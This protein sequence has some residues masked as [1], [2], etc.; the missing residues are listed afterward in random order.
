MVLITEVEDRKIVKP[1]LGGWR[2]KIT[3]I[4]YLNAISQTGPPPKYTSWNNY[5]SIGIQTVETKDETT[6]SA[7]NKTTQM[8]RTDYNVSNANDKYMTPKCYE[9]Y[10]D[11]QWRLDLNHRARI[12]QRNYRVYR[13]LKY[14][15]ECARKYREILKEC[16]R[17][18]DERIIM[19]RK[20]HEQELLRKINPRSRADFDM[21]IELIERWRC[22]RIKEINAR[23]FKATQCAENCFVLK[24]TVEMFNVIDKF[25]QKIREQYRTRKRVKFLKINSKPIKWHGYKAKLIEMVTLKT[26]KAQEYLS[27]FNSLSNDN[28]NVEERTELLLMLK[29]SLG[30]H[31]CVYA[32]DLIYLLDQEIMLLSRGIKNLSLEYLRK[33]ILC[34]YLKF[35]ANSGTCAC[36]NI[37]RGF[38]KDPKCEEFREPLEIKTLFC[39]SCRKVLPYNRFSVHSRLNKLSSCTSCTLLSDRSYFHVNYEPYIFILNY[40]RAEEK[41]NRCFSALA[42]MMQPKDIYYLVNNIWQNHSIISKNEDIY[43]LRLVR[44]NKH[45]EWSPWNCILL[46]EEEAEIH[47]R[48]DDFTKVYS[49]LLLHEILLKHLAAKN[50]FKIKP[51]SH[52]DATQTQS[53]QNSKN[54]PK[55]FRHKSKRNCGAT[56]I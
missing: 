52:P 3:G 32:F 9:P 36:T 14:M 49:K 12:I 44:Y 43:V 4:E 39:R 56:Q 37:R 46:T 17:Y 28:L 25:K 11:I 1:Y 15:K 41:R 47:Y 40:V 34:D 53:R 33:R 24:K 10:D 38:K 31:I 23:Y 26:Q 54:R 35:V 5:C 2:N 16:K 21:L 6:Q 51:S 55:K 13:L 29:K 27:I 50:Y 22:D 7:H 20:R 42:F 45:V 8:W 48:I 30:F 18:Q 19:Y